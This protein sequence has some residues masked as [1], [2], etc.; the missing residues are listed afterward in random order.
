MYINENTDKQKLY[1]HW[2]QN[3]YLVSGSRNWLLFCSNTT[4][5]QS[6][7]NKKRI[8]KN[9]VFLLDTYHPHAIHTYIICHQMWSWLQVEVDMIIR[10]PN[11][12]FLSQVLIFLYFT[13]GRVTPQ[14][15]AYAKGRWGVVTYDSHNCYLYVGCPVLTVA[16]QHE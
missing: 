12:I 11:H 5:Q 9:I 4:H 7:L 15:L 10:C 8:I 13:I 1:E 16:H 2:S 3:H 6:T 14:H